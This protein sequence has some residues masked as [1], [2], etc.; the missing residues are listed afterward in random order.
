MSQK[1]TVVL[2]GSAHPLRGGLAAYNERLA[3]EYRD[4]RAEVTI[5]SFSLQYPSLFFPGK[6]QYTSEPPPGGLTIKTRIN[7]INPMS[8]IRVGTEIK[9]LKPD[10]VI[11]KFWMPFM[12]PCLSTICRIIRKNKHTRII[13]IID[14]IIPHEKRIGDKALAG[15]FVRS[16]DGFVA[17]SRSVMDELDL[18]DKQKPKVFCPHPLYDNFG[19]AI[20]KKDAIRKLGLDDTWSY[21]LFFGFIRDY[22][23]LDLLLKAFADPRIREMKV[24]L[25][26]AGEFYCDPKPFR[27]IIDKHGLQDRVIMSNDF[28]PDNDVASY[29]CAADLVVQ[30]YKS[31][32]QSG[33]TQI[34]Y[35][36]NKPMVITNVGGLAEF[37]PDGK[38]GYVVQPDPTEIA[39]AIWKFYKEDKEEEFAAR[40]AIEKEKYSWK[41]MIEAVETLEVRGKT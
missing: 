34:A 36:F 26:V 41:N 32:T 17:M 33:V 25:L 37:V 2:I 35:H 30:P 38:A 5:Y 16:V 18:F 22:K 9:K 6:S 7:S 28:I 8:W 14:N 15:Y 1:K 13:S 21:I 31:A 23:G 24:K 27:E 40:V 11:V 19:D 3:G 10:L 4:Q 29:F 39:N 20:S 12:A